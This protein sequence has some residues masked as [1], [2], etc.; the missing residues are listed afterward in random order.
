MSQEAEGP[1]AC[2]CH[3]GILSGC[4]N[5]CEEAAVWEPGSVS[6]G[7]GIDRLRYV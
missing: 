6:K 7:V 3:P 4:L 5:V 2:L 1:R